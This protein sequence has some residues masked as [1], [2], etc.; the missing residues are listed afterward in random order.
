VAPRPVASGP[1]R[2][3]AAGTRHRRSGSHL[4][5][6]SLPY[7]E[8]RLAVPVQRSLPKARPSHDQAGA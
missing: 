3:R 8:Q 4:T 2:H 1:Q 7:P 6:F 5:A